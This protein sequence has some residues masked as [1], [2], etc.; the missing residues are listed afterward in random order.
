LVRVRVRVGVARPGLRRVRVRVRVGVRVALP[1]LRRVRLRL[2]L[3]VGVRVALPG[4]RR[5]L[6]LQCG[7]A[8]RGVLHLVHLRAEVA[9]VHHTHDVP[10]D[11]LGLPDRVRVAVRARVGG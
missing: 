2:R 1:G 10:R 9:V 6:E 5:V 4:L 3:G 8:S 7:H 11:L